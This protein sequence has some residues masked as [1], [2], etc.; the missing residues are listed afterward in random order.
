MEPVHSA[1][2]AKCESKLSHLA[3]L[4]RENKTMLKKNLKADRL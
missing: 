3:H 1:A 4:L 2:I